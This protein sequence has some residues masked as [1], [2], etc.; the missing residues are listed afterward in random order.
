L[1]IEIADFGIGIVDLEFVGRI[2]GLA[3]ESARQSGNRQFQSPNRQFQSPNRQFQ[4]PNRQF[5]SS[6]S[7]GNR[8]SQSSISNRKIRSP[9]SAIRNEAAPT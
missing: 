6:I 8:Q 7:I 1:P 9:Q 4:S 3:S 5:Q 2:E